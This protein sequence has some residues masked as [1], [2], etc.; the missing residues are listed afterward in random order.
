MSSDESDD[1]PFHNK[2]TFGFGAARNRLNATPASSTI[3]AD[4]IAGRSR[5]ST[6]KGAGGP[7]NINAGGGKAGAAPTPAGEQEF[8]EDVGGVDEYQAQLKVLW[9]KRTQ[10][11]KMKK[12]K[13]KKRK[14]RGPRSALKKTQ[15]SMYETETAYDDRTS[16]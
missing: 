1:D 5:A 16:F 12:K 3:K 14:N 7:L 8:T 6:I 13:T 10:L 9:N 2:S 11:M 15:T 4:S